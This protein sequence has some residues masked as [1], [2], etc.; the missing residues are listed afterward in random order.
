YQPSFG[1]DEDLLKYQEMK[2][3]FNN[4][5]TMNVGK[6]LSNNKRASKDDTIH[7]TDEQEVAQRTNSAVRLQQ[8]QKKRIQILPSEIHYYI[9]SLGM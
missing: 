8:Q 3:I 5:S 2:T 7:E 1:T 9:S 4:A 6:F